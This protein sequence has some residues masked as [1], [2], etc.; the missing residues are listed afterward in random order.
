MRYFFAVLLFCFSTFAQEVNITQKFLSN[1]VLQGTATL[2]PENRLLL[3]K[4]KPGVDA[5]AIRDAMKFKDKTPAK[6]MPR[7]KHWELPPGLAKKQTMADLEAT[8]Q[9]EFIQEPKTY[10]AEDTTPNDP[11][12]PQLWGMLTTQMP[13]AWDIIKQ[14]TSVV[15]A[16]VDTGVDFRHPDLIANLWT[17]ANGEHGYTCSNGVVMA[18]GAGDYGPGTHVA[19]T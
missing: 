5:D 1:D 9:F 12:Y 19:G 4:H 14:S 10:Y 17:G 18:G 13:K 15:V 2:L 7:W 11:L 6:V 8:G 3:V 16:V